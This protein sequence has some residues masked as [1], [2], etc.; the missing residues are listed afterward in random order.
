MTTPPG[1]HTGAFRD[2]HGGAIAADV[3][4]AAAAAGAGGG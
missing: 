3:G 4:K 1:A 2:Q